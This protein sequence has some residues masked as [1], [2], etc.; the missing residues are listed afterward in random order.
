MLSTGGAEEEVDI[1]SV[2]GVLQAEQE[3]VQN[4]TFTN[5]VNAQLAK[6]K[7]PSVVQDLFQ[8]LRDG[9]RLLDLL[10]V[11]SGQQMERERGRSNPV[12]WRS[13]IETA[14]KFLR[15][16]SIKLVNI[17]VP[18]IVEGKPTI[19]LGLIWSIILHFHI[20][21]LTRGLQS[22]SRQT[23]VDPPPG[24]KSSPTAPPPR[25][26]KAARRTR[27]NMSAKKTLLQW[28][29]EKA[30]ELGINVQDFS[31]S[32]RSGLAFVAIINALR[33]GLLD[34]QEFKHKTD[35]ENLEMVFKV[36]EQE[37]K[38]PKLL[39]VQDVDVSN[40][41]EKSMITYVSQFLQYS[42]EQPI[43]KDEAEIRTQ[44]HCLVNTEAL[45]ARPD[46]V[47]EH[48]VSEDDVKRDFEE[49]R[50]RIDACIEG[51][52]LFLKDRGSP[53]EVI[54]KHQETLKNFD[55]GI[56]ERFLEA[57]D[58]IK[59]IL[60]PQKKLFVEEMREQVSQNWEVVRSAVNSQLLQMKFK[61]EHNKFTEALE[62]CRIQLGMDS[63]PLQPHPA[64][65]QVF[66]CEG[67]S[68]TQ[69]EQHLAVMRQLCESMSNDRVDAEIIKAELQACEQCE[70]EL[71]EHV[72]KRLSWVHDS[73][74]S[75]VTGELKTEYPSGPDQGEGTRQGPAERAGSGTKLADDLGSED[76]APSVIKASGAS[77]ELRAAEPS[78]I[79]IQPGQEPA[80]VALVTPSEQQLAM[81][82]ETKCI[83]QLGKGILTGIPGQST[84]WIGIRL[85]DL[86]RDGQTQSEQK[87]TPARKLQSDGLERGD[88]HQSVTHCLIDDELFTAVLGDCSGPLSSM[89]QDGADVAPN[90]PRE[91]FAQLLT[92]SL[93][94]EGQAT[95]QTR[96]SYA[97]LVAVS[98]RRQGVV[99][100]TDDSG[101]QAKDLLIGKHEVDKSPRVDI[102]HLAE[103]H[104]SGQDQGDPPRGG[105]ALLASAFPNE[106]HQ[107]DLQTGEVSTQSQRE[108][109]GQKIQ[110]T[111]QTKEEPAQGA[112]VTLSEQEAVR[113]G[114]ECI[115]GLGKGVLTEELCLTGEAQGKGLTLCLKGSLSGDEQADRT[116]GE[117]SVRLP[118]AIL[119]ESGQADTQES[120]IGGDQ[121]ED[122]TLSEEESLIGAEQND[123]QT[124]QD[125]ARYATVK[126]REQAIGLG[127]DLADPQERGL[128]TKNISQSAEELPSVL[129][130]VWGFPGV[131]STEVTLVSL[132]ET[133]HIGRQTTQTSDPLAARTGC[134]K[135][136]D[137]D[138]VRTD[139]APLV[140]QFLIKRDQ[141]DGLVR[142][143]SAGGD[144][145]SVSEDQQINSSGRQ[146]S[147]QLVGVSQGQSEQSKTT[148][149]LIGGEHGESSLI[150]TEET[151]TQTMEESVNW[152]RV[153]LREEEQ[154]R[155]KRDPSEKELT[156]EEQS[157]DLLR[158]DSEQLPIREQSQTHTEAR[159]AFPQLVGASQNEQHQPLTREVFAQYMPEFVCEREQTGRAATESIAQLAKGHLIE[160]D[161]AY[162]LPEGDSQK[163]SAASGSE[164]ELTEGQA[165]QGPNQLGKPSRFGEDEFDHQTFEDSAQLSGPVLSGEIQVC[166]LAGEDSEQI[167]PESLG[168]Q[169]ADADPTG[170]E[171][172]QFGQK[173]L[174]QE[175][176]KGLK[177]DDIFQ[178][179]KELPDV[180]SQALSPLGLDSTE[181]LLTVRE[182]AGSTTTG[183]SVPLV[184]V[185]L[186]GQLQD[187]GLVREDSAP[188]VEEPLSERGQADG[189]V[190]EDFSGSVKES[191]SGEDQSE[192]PIVQDSVRLTTATRGQSD[193]IDTRESLSGGKQGED[194]SLSEEES[195]IEAEQTDTQTMEDSV[196]WETATFREQERAGG[197]WRVECAHSETGGSTEEEQS[198]D[199]LR[200]DSEQLPIREQSQTHTEARVNTMQFL[201]DQG[202]NYSLPR[203]AFP[204]LVGASPKEQH[205]PLTRELFAQYMPEFV[206]E[207]EQIG[208]AATESIAQL[209][210]GHLIGINQAYGL[211]EGDSQKL[212]AASG[213]ERELTE[214]QARQGPNQLGKPSR[215]GE[216]EF[217][218]QTFE[219]SAQL[220]G[221]VLSGEIQ[222][223]GLAGEDSE[224]IIPESLGGQEADADPTGEESA[225][226]G[227]KQ[228]MQEELKGL[229]RDDIFQSGKEL[230]D[231]ESQALSP[232]GLDS[233]E[234]LLTVREQAGSTTTGSSV[235]LVAVSLNG[236][237]QDQGLVRED[238]APMV[239]E[240]LSERGQVDGLVREDFS[241][242]VKESL[243]GEDQS[244]SS[245]VQDSVRL[246][247]ATRGQSDEIDTRES[248]SGGKQGEDLSL[249]E[250]E[251][252]IEAEQTDTQ[253]MEDSVSW[254][255]ATF[256]EQERA[257]GPWR[258]ECAHSETGG[259]TEEEQSYGLLRED[260]EQI[261]PESLGG[262][263][264]DA[265]PTGEE[266]A[267]F[268]QKQ[269]MQEELKGLK[270]DDIFQSG[271][272]L[273]DV[274]SQAL[275]PLGLDSTETLLTVREQAGST[276][277]GS[278]VPLV[279][280]SLNG[281]LQDQG[282]VREEEQSYSLLRE[283][284]EQLPIR[285]QSQTHTEARVNT[286]Q[287]L[288]GEKQNCGLPRQALP[289]LV[290]TS[291]SEQH[292]LITGEFSAC[293]KPGSVR[294]QEQTGR[295]VT[296]K[297]QHAGLSLS[298]EQPLHSKCQGGTQ[299]SIQSAERFLHGPE[300]PDDQQHGNYTQLVE[301]ALGW[302]EQASLPLAGSARVLQLG[303]E[304]ADYLERDSSPHRISSPQSA[305][306]VE[307]S[308]QSVS[309]SPN[310]EARVTA[311]PAVTRD[312]QLHGDHLAQ[313]DAEPF[314]KALSDVDSSQ[315]L[316]EPLTADLAK[317]ESGKS[318]WSTEQEFAGV[319]NLGLV[320]LSERGQRDKETQEEEDQSLAESEGQ[321][322]NMDTVNEIS[323]RENSL[324]MAFTALETVEEQITLL[325]NSLRQFQN[326]PKILNGLS[327][328]HDP[329]L[330]LLKNLQTQITSQIETCED[331]Q[332]RGSEASVTLDPGD[333]LA[334]SA[335]ALGHTQRCRELGLQVQVV[336]EALRAL[337]GF[338]QLLRA[339]EQQ[340]DHIL[341]QDG[342]VQAGTA[343]L[344]K[345]EEDTRPLWGRALDLDK[346]LAAAQICLMD[347]SSG[348]RTCC[349][350]LALSLGC[351][352]EGARLGLE[353]QDSV[354]QEELH[355]AF[356][357]RQSHLINALWEIEKRAGEVRLSE[358]TLPGV[359]RRLRSLND[360]NAELQL[361]A[362]ELSDLRDLT[363]QLAGVSSAFRGEAQAGLHAA[364]K[365]WE[366]TER[367]IHDWQD[368]CCVLVAFL[369]EF[370]NYKKELASTIQ[371]GEDVIPG[372]SS[373]LGKEKLQRVMSNIE[374]VKLECSGQQE[375]VD[376][377][378]KICRHL[379]SELRKIIGS[380]SLPFQREADELLDGWL[381]V[382][383]RLDAYSSSLELALSLW[384]DLA[385][386]G[387]RMEDWVKRW[388]ETLRAS[389]SGRELTLL[390]VRIKTFHCS[391]MG[392]CDKP[393]ASGQRVNGARPLF[394][395][396]EGP[397]MGTAHSGNSQ[398]NTARSHKQK[399]RLP[400]Q[401]TITLLLGLNPSPHST[402]KYPRQDIGAGPA[403][404]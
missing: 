5:W 317:A 390:E 280:V 88:C 260:S 138:V 106:Q 339:T 86:E 35:K 123:I 13:N 163:L 1:N 22:V 269:L 176:L 247:T 221:P 47:V 187:Q 341:E 192:S 308:A 335:V 54:T 141:A 251:S 210:K 327:L 49:S 286:M 185:S 227:Q 15:K 323:K 170:E 265:D 50:I 316:T 109:T 90:L 202:P 111:A 347:G 322:D 273:P 117:E 107:D 333:H 29:Q 350:D 10:E 238:S 130:Q 134:G 159:Q 37:L 291:Q 26:R 93:T 188:M 70:T 4:R 392:A 235:P 199:L 208:R 386:S 2:K 320:D 311:D 75:P 246:T 137:R 351:E 256:R 32:W 214:G 373:Y 264:A 48:W 270:R 325:H 20:E 382:S 38:I 155:E 298:E 135:L 114:T 259:S 113:P 330:Q 3:Q 356:C 103:E 369:R 152:E 275:S 190:R 229:K 195:L 95:D 366:E 232:L 97:Q 219:D 154:E 279:A 364:E 396:D 310:A 148:E 158:E 239:E 218:H 173:Q 372:S 379:Q 293:Y 156:E 8:D 171:S 174:M 321:E 79:D 7:S 133:E 161:Q 102:T 278:S 66:F 56:F 277:T 272:E 39:E 165:R 363:G 375:K 204:Q 355:K 357:T 178:S 169:E 30:K 266:S 177:R 388:S 98:S 328:K 207:R 346:T 110:V 211:P 395:V 248:L 147:V 338:L 240:S 397:F 258:V 73:V 220:S 253:T 168:G 304:Q 77:A 27:L 370:Q 43:A 271:K 91:D 68:L 252:L 60:T 179:G 51:A 212:S 303:E 257:G 19:I 326:E 6:H 387:S 359:Q 85:D 175:E 42:E 24:F 25:K 142:K 402:S 244:E 376:E 63:S 139:S 136:Q 172:A 126:L 181:T 401:V 145:R 196:S 197:P 399:E 16:K 354:A 306:E 186:N 101:Q 384:E 348:E 296:Q 127:R 371:K 115:A 267:Q 213:S 119:G 380:G 234:T 299:T 398:L 342:G 216:D 281:Q 345:E 318:A 254:E 143:E 301:E 237:L 146:D 225:Q 34:P 89:F 40:P 332:R 305:K 201:S 377:L 206:C 122:L 96:G 99:L 344:E 343:R 309:C 255:T 76:S 241:G 404:E 191:L 71:E 282:L 209:E 14:L 226:F 128:E 184:A 329:D 263:E 69:A 236:Q 365:A 250:E 302:E 78:R 198:Y 294:E 55:S 331:L 290:G 297:N 162:G 295:A 381:D 182:Q 52:M 153:R 74:E 289:H 403:G 337:D 285:E 58:K 242:S 313:E 121:G 368:Q 28:V 180:K 41:D 65:H 157:Y 193:E 400:T 87:E 287:F 189:L 374:E 268:G 132:I 261:I 84:E 112:V 245:I 334:V 183:S 11:L 274:K 100:A 358:A 314:G 319:P 312:R 92:Q 353:R 64:G 231:V 140:E 83:A 360:L 160:E 194:L 125:S 144:E 150:G 228:L 233:T 131:D 118:A 215:F 44:S 284:S 166:G 224:Q 164:R 288:S 151:D 200:E 389:V 33:P 315:P 46:Q 230:P 105:S 336:E 9:H 352:V 61:M 385:E 80:Q 124:M 222:V 243:S 18:D 72:Y 36:A 104:P 12:H 149:S 394:P 67:S 223:C 205:Q 53:E 23:H 249:S 367:D 361:K 300:R 217:D 203:Q 324:I 362:T 349:R 82:P 59:T 81:C 57:T 45:G 378:R 340:E 116:I 17:N 94:V 120:L 21:K 383:E 62:E 292:Q 167:I 307:D 31:S 108:R 391:T 129:S 283:D 393:I 276:T 262:Q